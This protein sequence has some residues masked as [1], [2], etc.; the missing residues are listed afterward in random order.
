MAVEYP[1]PDKTQIFNTDAKEQDLTVFKN[2]ESVY[3]PLPTNHGRS[4]KYDMGFWSDVVDEWNLYWMGQVW[5]NRDNGWADKGV[6]PEYDP[7]AKE[8]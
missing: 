6:D 1:Y 5:Q 3:S 7:F 4:F 2:I 8:N